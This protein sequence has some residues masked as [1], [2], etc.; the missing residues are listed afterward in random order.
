MLSGD[1]GEIF[2]ELGYVAPHVSSL[3]N[4]LEFAAALPP[5]VERSTHTLIR[6][7]SLSN[8]KRVRFYGVCTFSC[9]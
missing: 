4:L 8:P 2:I 1:D 6:S 9:I 3:R 7:S 5:S